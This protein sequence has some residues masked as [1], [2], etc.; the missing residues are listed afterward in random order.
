MSGFSPSFPLEASDEGAYKLN[1]TLKEVVSQNLMNL[2]LTSPG[3]R[4]MDSNFGVGIRRFLFEQ[5]AEHTYDIMISTIYNQIGAYMP[6]IE[7]EDVTVTP[8]S[9]NE[10]LA[11]VRVEYYLTP[12]SEDE[13]LELT[14]RK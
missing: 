4:I 8:S 2:L 3:E 6:F 13:V 12:L 9:S 1:K 5:N 7:I 14:V 11:N 10:F